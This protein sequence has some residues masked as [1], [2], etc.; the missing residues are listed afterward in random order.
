MIIINEV[1]KALDEII[2]VEGEIEKTF[3]YGNCL[4]IK[5]KNGNTY[6]QPLINKE[7]NYATLDEQPST[8]AQDECPNC[9]GSGCEWCA[10]TG[11]LKP[12][13]TPAQGEEWKERFKYWKYTQFDNPFADYSIP[14]CQA[15]DQTKD[16]MEENVVYPLQKQLAISNNE[17]KALR[18]TAIDMAKCWQDKYMGE[19]NRTESLQQSNAT[20]QE[21]ID[22][23]KKQL[24][25]AKEATPVKVLDWLLNY[26][27]ADGDRIEIVD[28]DFYWAFDNEGSHPMNGEQVYKIYLKALN[29]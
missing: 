24:Q 19:T 3:K 1:Q 20:L 12:A 25:E 28:G 26:H 23:L 5:F 4:V 9:D 17:V 6:K 14:Q 29:P 11:K 7:T 15:A 13:V 2:S 21:G 10:S 16:W 18:K 8:P 22:E 27:A